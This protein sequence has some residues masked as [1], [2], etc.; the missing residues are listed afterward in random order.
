M[1]AV[2]N[3]T[4]LIASRELRDLARDRL[5]LSQQVF[6]AMLVPAFLG[7][8]QL[9]AL[10]AQSGMLIVPVIVTQIANFPYI[11]A[12]QATLTAFAGERANRTL[13]PLLATP[14]PNSSIFSGKLTAVFLPSLA[15]SFLGLG[16]MVLTASC[17]LK[18][19][20]LPPI[21]TDVL[22]AAALMS[23]VVGLMVT[24]A[25]L[26]AST[27]VKQLRAAQATGTV[28]LLP[29]LFGSMYL[30]FIFTRQP[31]RAALVLLLML[32]MTLVGFL[33]GATQW[34]REEATL[35]AAS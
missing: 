11:G 34:R 2:A 33:W 16:I 26:L 22:L 15:F 23:P 19:R 5:L 1:S 9:P 30:S 27:K 12:F 32:P 17:R 14:V 13:A 29:I 20:G 31:L 4:W 7:W 18:Q 28:L 8:F 3:G 6:F 24:A 25:G 10:V 21:P 35:G